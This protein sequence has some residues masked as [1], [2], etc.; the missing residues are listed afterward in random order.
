MQHAPRCPELVR[1]AV[2]DG[3]LMG[4]PTPVDVFAHR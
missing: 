4:L 2:A 1:G 3:Y